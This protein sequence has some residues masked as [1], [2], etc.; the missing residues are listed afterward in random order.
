MPVPSVAKAHPKWPDRSSVAAKQWLP[1][2]QIVVEIEIEIEIGI[3]IDPCP[4][5][6]LTL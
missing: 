2:R 4:G 1:I 6:D 5:W 3:G